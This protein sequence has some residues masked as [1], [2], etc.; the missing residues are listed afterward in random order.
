MQLQHNQRVIYGNATPFTE[1]F[2]MVIN[3]VFK[4][5][6]NHYGYVSSPVH[7]SA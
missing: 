5:S 1:T 6:V 3:D 4:L 2:R 7:R